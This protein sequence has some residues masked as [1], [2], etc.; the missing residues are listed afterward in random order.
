MNKALLVGNLARDPELRKTK[1]DVSVCTFTI[2]CNRR[3]GSDGTQQADFLPVVVWRGLAENCYL[4]L[5]KGNRVAVSGS[6]QTRSYEAQDGSKRYATEIVAD[7]VEFINVRTDQPARK[8]QD[9]Y[10]A[11]IEQHDD[12]PF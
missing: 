5:K 6:I 3:K 2:A 8:T 10:W 12:L 1:S 9:D 7:E 11:E 4:Y